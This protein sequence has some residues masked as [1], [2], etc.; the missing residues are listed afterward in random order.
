[1]LARSIF[2]VFLLLTCAVS[3]AAA[4]VYSC[5]TDGKITYTSEPRGRCEARELPSVGRYDGRVLSLKQL[6]DEKKQVTE[7]NKK[8]L[9]RTQS[10]LL[11]N[12]NR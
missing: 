12:I 9:I 11:K 8:Q 2:G 7:A 10:V 6:A 5:R 3:A 1:M 4:P